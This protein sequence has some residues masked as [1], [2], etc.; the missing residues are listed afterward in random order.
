MKKVF[1]GDE[2][3][4]EDELL[5]ESQGYFFIPVLLEQTCNSII[6]FIL[7]KSLTPLIT[8]KRFNYLL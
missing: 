6:K 8:A 3:E 5:E 4:E 7:Q 2:S 1:T